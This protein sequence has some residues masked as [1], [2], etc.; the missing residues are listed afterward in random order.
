MND[1]FR[2]FRFE[3]IRSAQAGSDKGEDI[4]DRP[5]REI[6]DYR[7]PVTTWEREAAR[8]AMWA[9]PVTASFLPKTSG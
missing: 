3:E 6:P 9:D 2:L 5:M 7:T 4:Y 8:R 1:L